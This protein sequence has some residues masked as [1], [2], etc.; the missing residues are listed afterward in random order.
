MNTP[1]AACPRHA[2]TVA[3]E[4]VYLALLAFFFF[5]GRFTCGRGR[6]LP[7][8]RVAIVTFPPVVLY[9]GCCHSTPSVQ[10]YLELQVLAKRLT[11]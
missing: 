6:I 3:I 8:L 4:A 11:D 9:E 2:A 7:F 10:G 1:V 5:F